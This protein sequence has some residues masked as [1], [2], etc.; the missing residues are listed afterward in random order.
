MTPRSL[1]IGLGAVVVVFG[2]G[3]AAGLRFGAAPPPAPPSPSAS[4][5][6]AVPRLILGPEDAG[7]KDPKIVFDPSAIT[8]LPDASLRLDLPPGFDAGAP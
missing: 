3:L 8:L 5:I 7:A 6:P 4:A 1:L 2:A